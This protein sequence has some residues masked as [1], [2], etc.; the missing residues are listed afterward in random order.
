MT[1][2]D[3]LKTENAE[4]VTE[5]AL[6]SPVDV[7]QGV[8]A[9]ARAA[10]E[11]VD[12]LTVFDLAVS[13]LF[14]TAAALT[15][16][17]TDATTL[18]SRL[19][20]AATD[21][22]DPPP[23]LAVGE[24]ARQG[25]SI[26]AGLDPAEATA[27]E[28]AL[29]IQ[30]VRDFALWPP[31]RAA[32]AILAEALG[33][34][35]SADE[36]PS[37]PADLLPKSGVYPTERVFYSRLLI[38]LA[39]QAAQGT[40]PV[41]QAGA[42]DLGASLSAPT[43][44]QRLAVGALATFS[45]S[46]YSEGV[47][48]G[49]LLHSLTLAPGES[50]RIAL[51]DWS[52]RV[53]ASLT[54]QI[55]EREQLAG[56]QTHNRALTEVTDSTASEFQ[57]GHST[58]HVES[59]SGQSGSAFGLE[60]GPLA[61]GGSGGGGSSTTT[62]TSTASSF[63]ARDLAASLA[64]NINDR[65][66]QNASSARSRR[67][68]VVSE[69]SQ[70]E[71]ESIT[72][73]IV[74]NYNHMHALNVQYF[75]L[76]QAYRV[77]TELDRVER[78]LFVPLQLLDFHDDALVARLRTTLAQAALTGAAFRQLTSEYG[79][80]EIIP[81]T[82]RVYPGNIGVRDRAR[83]SVLARTI[84]TTSAVVGETGDS[85]AAVVETALSL[86]QRVA[87][88]PPAAPITLAAAKGWDLD[89]VIRLG[90]VMS[91]VPLRP[92]SDS[93]F[94]P[95]DAQLLSVALRDGQA[96]RFQVRKRDNTEVALNAITPTSFVLSAPTRFAD[97][98]AVS[99]QSSVDRD[100][101]TTLALNLNANNAVVTLDV[102]VRFRSSTSVPSLQDVISFGAVEPSPELVEHLEAYRLHYSR[103][104]YADLD[105]ATIAGILAKFTYRGVALT[106]VVDPQPVAMTA[107]FLVF[108]MNVPREG[109][110]DDPRFAEEQQEFRAFLTSRG[111]NT[112]VAKSEIVPL[113]TGGVFAE[114]VLGRFNAAEKI[115]LERFWNWQDSP[116]PIAAPEI[117][118]VEAGSRA[119]VD[120]TTPGQLGAPVL[121]QQAPTAL[122]A[123]AGVAPMLAAI[124][125]ANMFRDMSGLAQT[126]ALAQAAVTTTGA[127]ATAAGEQAAKNLFTVMDQNTQ[128]MRIAAD[129]I[130]SMYGD[131]G[132]ADKAKA[133]KSVSERGGQLNAADSMGKQAAACGDASAAAGTGAASTGASGTQAPAT[134]EGQ[135]LA[136]QSGSGA[137]ATADK[138][139][140]A[141][142]KPDT[143]TTT[144]APKPKPK[145]KP[146]TP[147]TPATPA[148]PPSPA[149]P[150][151]LSKL[152]PASRHVRLTAY[153]QTSGGVKI[154][155]S[156]LIQLRLVGFMTST[157][158]L[159]L[160][161]VGESALYGG[162]DLAPGV[163][164]L[165]LEVSA[166]AST[167]GGGLKGIKPIVL[168]T[169]VSDDT[170]YLQV[171]IKPVVNRK[172]FTV[173][174]TGIFA[175]DLDDLEQQLTAAGIPKEM[176]AGG[177]DLT[178]V[179][180]GGGVFSAVPTEF[181]ATVTYFSPE[182][183]IKQVL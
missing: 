133:G 55:D 70:A 160:H 5:A 92:G 10:L 47:T 178:P 77:T 61:L 137:A 93:V 85:T 125:Q 35:A 72:T 123:A 134:L 89:Q 170:T 22:V 48:L 90:S 155:G 51:L 164:S 140:D 6:T 56:T 87:D 27:L 63:G 18:E 98:Q 29:S 156:Q 38:D 163:A 112:A 11:A 68:S 95:D 21:A 173:P 118:P 86:N 138:I 153:F 151:D 121:K 20:G 108:R 67:A 171:N 40:T 71:H 114:A 32:K 25:L 162:F 78:C 129:L 33:G 66:Q 131:K 103:A 145:P 69:V 154:R 181:K 74:T 152:F 45:Q 136:Q 42:I 73:R 117:A 1:V 62:A 31:L 54:E 41:E 157:L 12:I 34:A 39:P 64:Q 126:A 139:V 96:A 148:T 50:T 59:E 113:P 176:R 109:D 57:S 60:I 135:T 4:L 105:A 179:G 2:S 115:D 52:R 100:V 15:A 127:G 159:E 46:W 165:S 19:N 161:G 143:G 119:E 169:N 120:T 43:A 80:V 147:T 36:D 97:L 88:G 23:G 124:Q 180:I 130:G 99:V 49:Q 132:G 175:P 3:L 172:T 44:F 76:V 141:A 81:R 16:A 65:T 14:A 24:W 150:I 84:P 104:A 106:R 8:T 174:T 107:N 146:A 30:T 37:T 7:L 111:L 182:L 144:S 102:P 28:T 75:E 183:I 177:P 128:R 166:G 91:G 53:S 82:P 101:T 26:L 122:P 94:V 58:T 142:T 110:P 158:L 13:H 17:E 149:P 116:I 9:D 79:A 167:Q 168:P 83:A